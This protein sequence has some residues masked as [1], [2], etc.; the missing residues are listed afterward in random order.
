LAIAHKCASRKFRCR[1]SALSQRRHVPK[2]PLGANTLA[3]R[4][5]RQWGL[6]RSSTVG[7]T[8]HDTRPRTR[9]GWG[10]KAKPSAFRLAALL[11][12]RNRIIVELAGSIDPAAPTA[13]RHQMTRGRA[14]DPDRCSSR[15]GSFCF[16]IADYCEVIFLA[17]NHD[18]LP[19]PWNRHFNRAD[20]GNNCARFIGGKSRN[21]TALSCLHEGAQMAA[22]RCMGG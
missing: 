10:T 5:V 12:H 3:C 7:S 22:E 4:T 17:Q 16:G 18:P 9:R 21:T 15:L 14:R 6:I 20:H 11:S 13:R 2:K 19:D 8:T 1:Q